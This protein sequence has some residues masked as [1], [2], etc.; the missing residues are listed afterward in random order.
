MVT[1][2]QS[3]PVRPALAASAS[4][5]A[6]PSFPSLSSCASAILSLSISPVH[7]RPCLSGP[8]GPSRDSGLRLPAA[9]A[10]WAPPALCA[11]LWHGRRARESPNK[12]AGLKSDSSKNGQSSSAREGG[13]SAGAEVGMNGGRG[14]KGG[15]KR[16]ELGLGA[17]EP[18]QGAGEGRTPPR[19]SEGTAGWT[20]LQAP[21]R[22]GAQREFWVRKGSWGPR[23]PRAPPGAGPEDAGWAPR[24]GPRPG[25]GRR[26][27]RGAVSRGRSGVGGGEAA[28]GGDAEGAPAAAAASGREGRSGASG[29][30]G[31]GPEA[32]MA[33]PEPGSRGP[34][35][36][37]PGAQRLLGGPLLAGCI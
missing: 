33:R 9:V 26:R 27:P 14:I 15:Y 19:S 10:A 28:G 31:A 22:E 21:G 17:F 35:R 34:P 11:L 37:A 2:H 20:R 24:R 32:C 5:T 3:V 16:G 25:R 4:P 23:G 30:S 18:K 8:S 6:S 7:F 36:S 13:R 1:T 29:R 12:S